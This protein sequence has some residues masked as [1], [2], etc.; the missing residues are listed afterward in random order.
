MRLEIQAL[1]LKI[2]K[3]KI[4]TD[5]ITAEYMNSAIPKK[6]F[7]IVLLRNNATNISPKA[8]IVIAN[9]INLSGTEFFLPSIKIPPQKALAHTIYH[10]IRDMS[11]YFALSIYKN[12]FIL[13]AKINLL[14]LF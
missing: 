9:E 2:F 6:S 1:L 3:T 5:Y 10:R 14:N 13:Y 8:N 4:D 7:G 12:S 11:N